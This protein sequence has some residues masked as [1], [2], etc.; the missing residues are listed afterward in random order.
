MMRTERVSDLARSQTRERR[1]EKLMDQRQALVSIFIRFDEELHLFD[2]P[3]DA[4]ELINALPQGELRARAQFAIE[5]YF[6]RRKEVAQVKCAIYDAEPVRYKNE[7]AEEVFGRELFLR[8]TGKDSKGSVS[9][10]V[11]EGY[12]VVRCQ[13]PLDYNAFY[14]PRLSI[15]S[16][17]GREL[18]KHGGTYHRAMPMDFVSTGSVDMPESV[19]ASILLLKEGQ[20]VEEILIHERQHFLNDVLLDHFVVTEKEPSSDETRYIKDE[21]LAYIRDGSSGA[22]LENSLL[23]ALYV[24]LFDALPEAEREPHRQ[25]V[26]DIAQ[27][28]TTHSDV[29]EREYGRAALVAQLINV[30]LH[31]ISAYIPHIATYYRKRFHALPFSTDALV[32]YRPRTQE[33]WPQALGAHVK[34]FRKNY[35]DA[36]RAA[37]SIEQGAFRLSPS[38]FHALVNWHEYDSQEFVLAYEALCISSVP[39]SRAEWEITNQYNQELPQAVQTR[40][41]RIQANKL[42]QRV[43]DL[44]GR[45]S[46]FERADVVNQCIRRRFSRDAR[47]YAEP[48][49]QLLEAELPEH[50]RIMYKRMDV[51]QSR[52]EIDITIPLRPGV[53]V[54]V[55]CSVY[56]NTGQ[57]SERAAA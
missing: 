26:R 55:I 28:L 6:L 7:S 27:A 49:T 4:Q 15:A 52:I 54:A 45:L 33:V 40:D 23:G 24:E 44:L 31:R 29:F 46:E 8:R 10:M 36:M 56:G 43:V 13:N 57:V 32:G 11:A 17:K 51:K 39:L 22:G 50:T 35:G 9:A 25:Y 5:E 18:R 42:A 48:I 2:S 3:E 12:I 20:S 16:K 53:N 41:L 30:P 47:V 38:D 14:D 21:V 37:T 34:N 19:S 1:L